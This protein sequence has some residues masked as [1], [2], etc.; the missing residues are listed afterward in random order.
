MSD[1]LMIVPAGWTEAP[2]G[3][4]GITNTPEEVQYWVNQ[5]DWPSIE[6][7]LID[8]GVVPEGQ[9]VQNAR[10]LQTNDGFRLWVIYG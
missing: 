7:I 8:H 10:L 3:W 4:V 6:A 9:H 1:F 5:Q 2:A